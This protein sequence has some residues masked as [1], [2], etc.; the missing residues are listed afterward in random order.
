MVLNL[1]WEKLLICELKVS[2]AMP[3]PDLKEFTE[4]I[5]DATQA[6]F[7]AELLAALLVVETLG[8]PACNPE[9]PVGAMLPFEPLELG[10]AVTVA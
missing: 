9:P 3:S 1:V 4:A 10:L 6:E 7:I 5:K 8:D 2:P